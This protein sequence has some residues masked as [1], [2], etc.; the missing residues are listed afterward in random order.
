MEDKVIEI[1]KKH[2]IPA[3]RQG[4]L[5]EGE[6]YPNSFFTFWNNASDGEGFYNNENSQVV[7]DF[8][9]NLYSNNPEYVYKGIKDVIKDFKDNG[10]IITDYGHDV[11]SD[12]DTHI[13]RGINVLYMK[14]KEE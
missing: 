3:H 2:N 10:F 12:K 5:T 14:N 11:I 8:D 4:S 6:E 13:G 9:V 7:Y 1:L